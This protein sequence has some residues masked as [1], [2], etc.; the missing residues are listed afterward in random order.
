MSEFEEPALAGSFPQPIA[1]EDPGLSI[2]DQ[3]RAL[4]YEQL[5]AVLC[6]QGGGQ[7]YGSVIAFAVNRDLNAVVFATPRATRKFRLL[8][9]CDH[10]A[11]V[12][13][14]RSAAPD[15]LSHIHAVTATGRAVDLNDNDAES[16]WQKLL[17]EKHPLMHN[18]ICAPS[19]ALIR[20][21]ILRYLHVT[22]LQEVYQWVP[23]P[24][25]Q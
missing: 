1:K 19:T 24:L 15:D 25:S 22:R 9:D 12:V 7:P 16:R 8:S 3:I 17:I 5:Y 20:I 2:Q 10:V 18:F 6:T 23:P 4:M 11:L 13:D 21:D 14:N